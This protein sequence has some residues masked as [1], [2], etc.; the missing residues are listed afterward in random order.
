[1]KIGKFF[2]LQ[3]INFTIINY[4]SMILLVNKYLYFCMRIY[5]QKCIMI[6]KFNIT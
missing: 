1:M 6:L 3:L 4:I 5:L 2:I